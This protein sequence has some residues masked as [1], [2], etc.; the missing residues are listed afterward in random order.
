[1]NSQAQLDAIAPPDGNGVHTLTGDGAYCFGGFTMTS[2]RRIV[3]PG[4]RKIRITGHGPLSIVQGSVN[5]L[6]LFLFEANAE[7]HLENLKIN[8]TGTGTPRAVESATTE[9]YAVNCGMLCSNG[10]GIRVTG[11]RF[12]G[13]QVRIAN[14]VTGVSCR[15]GEVFLEHYDCEAVGTCAN[16]EANHIALQWIGGRMNAFTNGVRIAADCE[17]IILQGV[18]SSSGGT[19]V[20]HSGTGTVNRAAL[21][22]NAVK[23]MTTAINWPSANIPAAGLAIVGNLFNVSTPFT[24]FSHTSARVNAKANTKN[25]SPFLLAETPIVT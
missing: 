2:G 17:H 5:S 24:G 21:M 10:E 25:V 12:F 15:G 3:V 16:V 22:N 19:W 23:G 9:A 6:P 18:T 13:T 1:V 11:G 20:L 4:A 7:V 14:C 8:N